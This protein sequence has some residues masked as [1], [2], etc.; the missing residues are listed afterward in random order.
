MIPATADGL[1]AARLDEVLTVYA[2]PVDARFPLVC[3]DESGKELQQEYRPPTRS[4]PGRPARIDHTFVHTGSSTFMLFVAP[5]LGWRHIKLT[6]RR[7]ARDFGLAMRD[8]VDRHFPDAERITVVLDNLN[9]HH[10]GSI[11]KTFAPAEAYRIASRLV[12]VHT[13]NHGSWV[14]MAELEFRALKAQCLARRIPDRPTLLRE[15]TAWVA[16]RNA[17]QVIVSWSFTVTD[18]HRTMPQVYPHQP[19][20]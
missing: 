1:Y 18:A 16:D 3:F 19:D 15:I 20:T 6:E 13:P 7:T 4:R 2:Q 12:F 9:I 14:N 10:K 5:W 11:Y 17:H 8:L